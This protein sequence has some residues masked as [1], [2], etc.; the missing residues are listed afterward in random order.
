MRSYESKV[1]QKA[2]AMSILNDDNGDEEKAVPRTPAKTSARDPVREVEILTS[3]AQ[4]ILDIRKDIEAFKNGGPRQ[5][6]VEALR[7]QFLATRHQAATKAEA[8]R[9][10]A[11]NI[12]QAR[13][14]EINSTTELLKAISVL[15]QAS[16]HDLAVL[17]GVLC[18]ATTSGSG[19]LVNVQQLIGGLP[20]REDRTIFNP[21]A[22]SHQAKDASQHTL[23]SIEHLL[24]HIKNSPP[25]IE[26]TRIEKENEPDGQGNDDNLIPWR[27][28]RG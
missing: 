22:S 16:G 1:K 14:P 23:E 20:E 3:P 2:T 9:I 17:S 28:S 13:L 5:E 19:A 26:S 27:R 4:V 15:S 7:D 6:L 8:V 10:L 24:K 18:G 25:V 12:L 21:T 11:L